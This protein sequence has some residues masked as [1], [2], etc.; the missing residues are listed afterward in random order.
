MGKNKG[1]TLVE[2][3]VVIAI[4]GI[5]VGLLLPAVQ[6]AREAARR[7][8]C[9]NNL[10]QLGL[11]QHNYESANRK[12]T[13][14]CGGT[15]GSS[16]S[17]QGARSGLVSLM[18][19]F[20][21]GPAYQ[22][23][24]SDVAA[25][26][27]RAS[28]WGTLAAYQIPGLRCPSEI[29]GYF[30]PFTQVGINNYVFNWGDYPG[31]RTGPFDPIYQFTTSTTTTNLDTNGPFQ[32]F[33]H[34]GFK[35]MTDGSSNTLMMS[36]RA[37]S[38]F[39]FNDVPS[40]TVQA[41]VLCGV[42][43]GGGATFNPGI[44][45]AT[46]RPLISGR[47]YVASASPSLRGRTGGI[48]AE[49]MPMVGAFFTILGPNKPSCSAAPVTGNGRNENEWGGMILN[50]NSFHTGG[51]QAVLCDGSVR[52]VSDSIDTGNVSGASSRGGSSP[53]GVWG[54]LGTRA[55]GEVVNGEF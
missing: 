9:S 15:S 49:G 50:A 8:Q 20:E 31:S 55:G 12:F 23:I 14:G 19:Y 30:I 16:A 42:A 17:N 28:S 7:M 3:L 18:P 47:N 24:E 53:Y 38:Q 21:F 39:G 22:A 45:L 2:L 52:F 41:G 36:E 32:Q 26:N 48:W 33:K 6:A 1:F 51:V 10:K 5:L 25:Q 40:P 11:A 46:A 43:F 44:C 35:E 27:K 34:Y 54:A 29:G 4:I 13:Y 37:T